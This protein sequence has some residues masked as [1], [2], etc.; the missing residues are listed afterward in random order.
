VGLVTLVFILVG[1]ALGLMIAALAPSEEAVQV[2]GS[3]VA[4]ILTTLGGGMFPLELGP[5]WLKTV[6]RLLPTGWAMFAYHTL[7][8]QGSAQTALATLVSVL[9]NLLVLAG[10]AAVFL[11]IGILSLRWE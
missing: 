7:M 6:A 9:P 4:L 2:I 10:F 11:V 1:C 5:D 8:W 3:P